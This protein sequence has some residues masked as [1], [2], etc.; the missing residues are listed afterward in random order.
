[1][2]QYPVYFMATAA[3]PSGTKAAWSI[4]C[5]AQEGRCAVPPEFA[6]AGGGF[7]P[8]DLY[9][10]ALTNCFVAT[11]KVY[12][13]MSHLKFEQIQVESNLKVDKNE[14][15]QPWMAA[16]DFK[17]LIRGADKPDRIRTLVDKAIKSGFVLNSVKTSMNWTV[18]IT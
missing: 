7:S 11:L 16:A 12:A 8:E 4:Q 17:V 15:G 6:G 2:V 9:L 13:E 18:D 14:K 1:M 10:Q 3:A 5:G